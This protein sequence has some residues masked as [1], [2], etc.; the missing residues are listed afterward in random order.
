M[1]TRRPDSPFRNPIVIGAITLLITVIAVALAYNANTGLPFVPTYNLNVQLPDAAGLN[2]SD[3]VLVGGTRVG[4]VGSITPAT[5]PDGSV[6]AVVHLKLDKA[7]EPLPADSTDLVR[8]V[9]PLGLKYLEIE[10]G[11][12]SQMLAPGAT[13]PVSHTHLPVEI[14]D[15][16]KMFNPPTRA[17]STANLDAFGDA[18]A[19]RGADLNQSLHELHPLVDDLLSVTR[20]LND[21]RTGW[22]SL[23]GSLERTANEDAS[24]ATQQAG[25]F[26][27]LDV[28]FTPLSQATSALQAA[29]AGGPSALETGTRE[30]PAQAKFIDDST[31]LFR[32]F[33]PAFANLAGASRELAPAVKAGVPA[34]RQ[35]PSLNGRLVTTLTDLERFAQDP[36]TLPGLVL[37]TGTARLLEPT[38]AFATPAQTSCNYL[39]LFFRN[40]ESAVSES[41]V[42]GSFLRI[43]ILALPQVPNSEAG[44]SSAP[45]N[46]PPA[47][48]GA[49]LTIKTLEDD[50]FLHSNPYP[51]TDAPGQMPECE[52]G[53]EHYIKGRQVIGNDPGSQ[54]LV[55]ERTK[56]VLP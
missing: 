50:S 8:P 12:S 39:T 27:G 34:L 42:V 29:I 46:G 32:R 20:N 36:R 7:I 21:P 55:T 22:S 25:L 23:F 10:R 56:R 19:G 43:G 54:G 3:S 47:P 53:N 6:G 24:V 35:A 38:V 15:V 40:L 49:P 14:D 28:T 13:I 9:S 1:K 26:A 11:H 52:G 33:Q 2:A 48:A 30:L 5:L 41:D 45:A 17:A 16:L 51:N 31:E 4:Y 18:F 37:L 44:P